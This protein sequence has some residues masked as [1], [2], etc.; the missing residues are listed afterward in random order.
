MY[1]SLPRSLKTEVLVTSRVMVDPEQL[2]A[3]KELIEAKKPSELSRINGLNDFP[4]PTR[5]ETLMRNKRRPGS[6]DLNKRR[7]KFIRLI[8]IS[9]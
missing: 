1:A 3:R 7:Y 6:E 8:Q 2:Q 9:S 4:I 5:I